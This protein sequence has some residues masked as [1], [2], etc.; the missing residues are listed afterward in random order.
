MGQHLIFP[1]T[2]FPRSNL[3]LSPIFIILLHNALISSMHWMSAVFKIAIKR[4]KFIGFLR[5]LFALLV[6]QSFLLFSSKAHRV[7]VTAVIPPVFL[8]SFPFPHPYFLTWK[9]PNQVVMCWQRLA[10]FS[11]LST[12]GSPLA[13]SISG[14]LAYVLVHQ[15]H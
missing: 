5:M 3:E 4:P 7:P 13:V 8:H 12:A 9:N 10:C 6:L 2:C 1:E 11:H 14:L 15:V